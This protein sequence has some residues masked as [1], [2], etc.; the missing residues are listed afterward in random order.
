MDVDIPVLDRSLR[1]VP[2]IILGGGGGRRQRFFLKLFCPEGGCISQVKSSQVSPDGRGY[3]SVVGAA[4]I[5][6]YAMGV[7]VL[8]LSA[9]P[10]DGEVK[11]LPPPRIIS[12]TALSVMDFDI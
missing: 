7:R 5:P 3:S 12:G 11:K 10:W 9:C 1:A 8:C 4:G 2:E 6:L